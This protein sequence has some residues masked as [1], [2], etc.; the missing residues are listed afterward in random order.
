MDSHLRQEVLAGRA[1]VEVADS[2]KIHHWNYNSIAAAFAPGRALWQLYKGKRLSLYANVMNLQYPYA[3]SIVVYSV[4]RV[5]SF[6]VVPC[7]F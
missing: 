2:I 4:K 6:V 3:S 1:G 5:E 7:V